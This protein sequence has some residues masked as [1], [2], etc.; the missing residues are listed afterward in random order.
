MRLPLKILLLFVL[1]HLS[2][3]FSYSQIASDISRSDS[4]LF[5][6]VERVWS[7]HPNLN[8]MTRMASAESSA[9]AMNRAWMNPELILGLMNFPPDFDLTMDPMTMFQ[10]GLMQRIPFPGKLKS[11]GA[12]AEAKYH[13]SLAEWEREKYAMAE[14]FAMAYYDFLAQKQ[15]H[16]IYEKGEILLEEMINVSLIMS[17]SG[18]GR[19]SEV[20]RAK[21]EKEEWLAK[22]IQNQS[23]IERKKAFLD[24]LLAGFSEDIVDF[25]ELPDSL[26]VVPKS[27][28]IEAFPEKTRAKFE[29]QSM[30]KRL[31]SAKLNY[32]P[33]VDVMVAYGIR[34][35]YG[36]PRDNMFSV[37]LSLPLPFFYKGNQ[38]AVAQETQAMLQTKQ[39]EL[40]NITLRKRQQMQELLLQWR[41]RSQRL[42]VLQAR[43][44]P[45]LETAW[46]FL[47]ID[48][49]AGKANYMELSEIRMRLLMS[50]MEAVMLKA[51]ILSIRMKYY[52]S[53]GKLP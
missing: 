30:E 46:S 28:A 44:L 51:E 15:I 27:F 50:E 6:L 21:I 47:L 52:T 13:G 35:D 29:L 26:P 43:I 10:I 32:Y 18:M 17:Q 16:T 7:Q 25:G 1:L 12:S 41:E 14:M 23:E 3:H 45:Q 2:N 9:I 20:L 11:A 8:A 53:V 39:L 31:Q 33:D 36:M 4:I 42:Y 34:Q 38:K 19:Q 37:E 49:R 5:S 22:A 48:Y 40:E 24:Y